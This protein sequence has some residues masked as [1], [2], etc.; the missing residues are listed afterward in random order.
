MSDVTGGAVPER[1]REL[2]A[3][4]DRSPL[5]D[6]ALV[7]YQSIG[8]APGIGEN[9]R[10]LLYDDGRLFGAANTP[11]P[12]ADGEERFNVPLP[13]TP[14]A[15]LPEEAVGRVR[16]LLRSASFSALPP[17]VDGHSVRDGAVVIVTARL[18]TG[19]HEVWFENASTELTDQLWSLYD[20]ATSQP[21][22]LDSLLADLE[23]QP[24]EEAT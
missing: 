16:E 23:E 15:T 4:R 24:G 8:L 20:E 13:D 5:P 6:G 7:R 2:L 21:V 18:D 3:G 10:F 19:V 1:L 17:Y 11:A 9:L 14:T 22:D 12:P